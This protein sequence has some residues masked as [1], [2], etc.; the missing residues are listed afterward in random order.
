MFKCCPKVT[1]QIFLCNYRIAFLLFFSVEAELAFYVSRELRRVVL[2]IS[3]FKCLKEVNI[4]AF[5]PKIT[6]MYMV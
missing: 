3:K 2:G 5:T 4:L 6:S 1:L